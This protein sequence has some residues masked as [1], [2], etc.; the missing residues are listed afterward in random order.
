MK[1]PEGT[2]HSCPN[3][4]GVAEVGWRDETKRWFRETIW[5]CPH[6]KQSCDNR[7]LEEADKFKEQAATK[8]QETISG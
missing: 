7:G 6:C 1:M 2:L 8:K 5:I 4:G 3:C